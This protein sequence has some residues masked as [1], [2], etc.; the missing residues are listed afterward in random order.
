MIWGVAA[1]VIWGLGWWLNVRLANG[2]LALVNLVRP[3]E[4]CSEVPLGEVEFE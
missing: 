1:I 2:A 4:V 3:G